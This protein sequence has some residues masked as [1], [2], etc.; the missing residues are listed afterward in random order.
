MTSKRLDALHYM[1]SPSTHF[2]QLKEELIM[3][4]KAFGI[5][6]KEIHRHEILFQ[7]PQFNSRKI[8]IL[9]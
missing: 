6:T 3:K 8:V 2:L 9:E 1:K 4:L 7:E 5:G